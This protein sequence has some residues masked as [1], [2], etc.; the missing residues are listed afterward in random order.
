MFPM[1][2]F[3]NSVYDKLFNVSMSL[4]YILVLKLN[5]YD[6]CDHCDHYELSISL[7][8]SNCD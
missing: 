1:K 8:I 2:I 4:L 6:H 7:M 5:S 3:E